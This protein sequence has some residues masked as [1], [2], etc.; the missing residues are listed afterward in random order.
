MQTGQ[1]KIRTGN[2]VTVILET[3]GR[4]VGLQGVVVEI[5]HDN[6]PDGPIGVKFPAYCKCNNDLPDKH[7]TIIRFNFWELRKD[8]FF[9]P[10]LAEE[11]FNL[12]FGRSMWHTFGIRTQPLIPGLTDCEH[13]HCKQKAVF[14]IWVNIWGTVCQYYVCPKHAKYHGWNVEDF[15][16]KEKL[17]PIRIHQPVMPMVIG[18]TKCA[19]KECNRKAYFTIPVESGDGIYL[20]YVCGEH[21][22]YHG[23]FVDRNYFEFEE[24]KKEETAIK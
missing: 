17:D 1:D 19:F 14:A 13:E 3:G 21:A 2:I 10:P 22:T 4:Y 20:I 9:Q 12:L 23:L 8:E 11:Q 15:N 7:N 16:S 24:L 6:N 18:E 5:K